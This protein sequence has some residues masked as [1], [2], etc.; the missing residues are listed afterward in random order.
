MMKLLIYTEEEGGEFK[1]LFDVGERWYLETK[2]RGYF[3]LRTGD[4][5]RV[6]YPAFMYFAVTVDDHDF[7]LNRSRQ[8]V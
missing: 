7:F 8:T 1:L 3:T 5:R 6:I 4:T 2:E